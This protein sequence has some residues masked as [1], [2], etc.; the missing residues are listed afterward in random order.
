MALFAGIISLWLISIEIEFIPTAQLSGWRF[1][2][3]KFN[4]TQQPTSKNSEP[5]KFDEMKN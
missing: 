2:P 1:P 4:A 5:K 3:L